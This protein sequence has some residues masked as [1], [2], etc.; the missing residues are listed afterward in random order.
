MKIQ[1]SKEAIQW[2]NDLTQLAFLWFNL[3]YDHSPPPNQLFR[4]DPCNLD[5]ASNMIRNEAKCRVRTGRELMLV[6]DGVHHEKPASSQPG[7]DMVTSVEKGPT[8]H[9]RPA[10]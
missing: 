6:H 8:V 1:H 7:T 4:C 3:S 9:L 5:V 10:H 2:Q